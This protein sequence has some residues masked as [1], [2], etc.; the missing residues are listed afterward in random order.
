VKEALLGINNCS[1]TCSPKAPQPVIVHPKPR[2]R[3]APL[4]APLRQAHRP[5]PRRATQ[6]PQRHNGGHSPFGIVRLGPPCRHDR[7]RCTHPGA[8]PILHRARPQPQSNPGGPRS[9]PLPSRRRAARSGLNIEA[10][11]DRETF[12]VK[13]SVDTLLDWLAQ[14]DP[15]AEARHAASLPR[16]FLP[17]GGRSKPQ[18]ARTGRSQLSLSCSNSPNPKRRPQ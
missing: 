16:T 2:P 14:T 13:P 7:S 3:H 8:L 11:L 17:P 5:A 12:N 9:G 1:T 6:E 15:S 10:E 18:S 4:P